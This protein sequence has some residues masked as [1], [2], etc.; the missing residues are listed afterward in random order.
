[1]PI[2]LECIYKIGIITKL[3]IISLFLMLVP[4]YF[5]TIGDSYGSGFQ[6]C[7]FRYQ[8]IFLGS[9]LVLISN[10]MNNVIT[11]FFKG[12]M[13][14][15]VILWCLGSFF[16]LVNIVLLFVGTAKNS[17]ITRR[18]GILIII[19]GIFYL[20]SLIVHYGPLFHNSIGIA[21]PLGLPLLFL[22]GIWMFRWKDNDEKL[23]I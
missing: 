17:R 16:L 12:A 4:V 20:V 6:T 5:F 21:I 22:I 9:F 13:I 7:F 1:M 23:Q 3:R 8:E 15:T 2:N 19:S 14:P 11:G 10:D 18:S